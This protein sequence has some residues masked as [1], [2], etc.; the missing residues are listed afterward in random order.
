MP[1]VRLAV[2]VVLLLMVAGCGN[3]RPATASPP[4]ESGAGARPR[5]VRVTPA[6]VEEVAR[7]VV[8]TGTLAAEEQIVLSL[9]VP[10]RLAEL[11]VDL[12]SRVRR[13]QPVARLDPTDFRLRVEQAESALHQARVRLGLPPEG[14]DDRIDARE[15]SVVRQAQAVLEEARLTRERMARLWEQQLVARAQLDAA[16]AALQ[17]AE[18]R[19]QDALEEV[20]NRQAVLTQRRVEVALARQQL[21]DTVLAAPADG[22]IR[23][24]RSSVGEFL[25]AGAPVATMVR[26]HPLRLVLAVP[27][28]AAAGVREGQA[29]R[30]TV[31]G[32]TAVHPGR[33][34]RLSPSFQEQSRT[35]TI[36]A[37][38]PNERGLLRPG[39]FARAEI[40]TAAAEPVIFVPASSVV[41]FAGIEKVLSVHEGKAVEKRVLTG[42][43]DGTRVEITEGLQAGEPVVLDPGN[44]VGGQPVRVVSQ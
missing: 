32:D 21:A 11:L 34:A 22:M 27:E 16:V 43:R 19:Y 39:A 18:G 3:D 6:K 2:L 14:T 25:A 41:T 10:G 7:S 26:V 12:G 30:V 5:D 33:V 24:R 35:L 44:L 38:V 28:R 37:E 20:R 31:E 15:T 36:E 23:E 13:G 29:V 40:V 17:V 42:R 8:V 9:K 1:A 4:R